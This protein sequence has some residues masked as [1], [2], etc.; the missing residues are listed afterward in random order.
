MRRQR[1]LRILALPAAALVAVLGVLP[2]AGGPR[3]EDAPAPSPGEQ[4]P[5][6]EPAA[7]GSAAA[8]SSPAGKIRVLEP[9]PVNELLKRTV[10]DDRLFDGSESPDVA[11]VAVPPPAVPPGVEGVSETVRAW[12]RAWSSRDADRSGWRSRGSRRRDAYLDDVRKTLELVWEDGSWKIVEESSERLPGRTAEM[13]RTVEDW[14]AAWSSQEVDRYLSYYSREFEVPGGAT[15]QQWEDDRRQRITQPRSIAVEI[16]SSGP[17]AATS[18]GR[19]RL[20]FRQAY[21]S[22]AFSDVVLKTLEL[23]REGGGWKIVREASED[24]P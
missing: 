12:A 11:A 22:D 20:S 6:P 5:V 9:L 8:G 21:A 19:F 14:A 4:A 10:L 1:H 23:V 3:Q 18:A 17:P 13:L 24:W 2:A 7:E 15:R 16:S